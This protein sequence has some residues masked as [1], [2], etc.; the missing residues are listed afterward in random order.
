MGSDQAGRTPG[1]KAMH[2]FIEVG[3]RHAQEE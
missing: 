3:T 2:G 1:G